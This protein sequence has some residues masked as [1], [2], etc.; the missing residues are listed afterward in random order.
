MTVPILFQNS[1]F[2]AVDKPHGLSVHN[3]EDP[4]NLLEVMEK[5]LGVPKLYPVHRLDKET[6]GVQ[7][8]ALNEAAAQQLG[9]EFQRGTVQKTYVGVLCGKLKQ[10]AGEWDLPLADKAEGRKNP[11]GLVGDRIFC[12][13]QFRA[14]KTSPYFTL[15]EFD[16]ITGRQHQIRKHAVLAGHALAGDLRYGNE[17]YNA[18][19]AGWHGTGRMFLHCLRLGILGNT[20][21]SALPSEFEQIFITFPS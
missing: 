21:E 3:K 20:I 8:L 14:L 1:D 19:I 15:C 13:T 2:V 18:K 4:T 17:K 11:A 12:R 16:L 10:N 7:I 9:G 6:S 5:Q